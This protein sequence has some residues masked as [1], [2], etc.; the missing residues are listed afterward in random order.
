MAAV[1]ST[2]WRSVEG[3]WISKGELIEVE[4]WRSGVTENEQ[5]DGMPLDGSSEHLGHPRWI[6]GNKGWCSPHGDMMI[7]TACCWDVS[8]MVIF[9]SIIRHQT[10]FFGTNIESDL[11]A[12]NSREMQLCCRS[13]KNQTG[14]QNMKVT[15]DFLGFL[16][17]IHV[18]QSSQWFRSYGLWRL[19]LAARNYFII[20]TIFLN[21]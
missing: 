18:S 5:H 15:K 11:I 3:R 4:L 12:H 2:T 8:N 16:M 20:C 21:I 1:V 10:N 7:L 19:S 6:G 9:E 17:V 14:S 13:G